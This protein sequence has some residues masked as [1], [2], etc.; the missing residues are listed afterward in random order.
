MD[1]VVTIPKKRQAQV[2]A[3]EAD[4]KRRLAAGEKPMKAGEREGLAYFWALARK[5]VKLEVGDR[6]YFVWDGA[7]RA[8]HEVLRFGEDLTCDFTGRPYRGCCIV[9]APEIHK[10]HPPLITPGFRG[11]R[12]TER[13]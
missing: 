7:I 12:Y 8:W 6:V 3:E 1:V 4:V 2:E 13:R 9:L 5:P 10:M 11:F